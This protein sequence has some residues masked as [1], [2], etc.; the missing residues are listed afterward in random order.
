MHCC[1]IRNGLGKGIFVLF[2]NA[3]IFMTATRYAS[4]GIFKSKLL[5]IKNFF[6]GR[7]FKGRMES[8]RTEEWGSVRVGGAEVEW[9][10]N[11]CQ[12]DCNGEGEGLESSNFLRKLFHSVTKR[13][14]SQNFQY[15]NGI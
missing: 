9:C 14:T 2:T 5:R 10:Q 12:K 4:Q 3:Q 13:L 8:G 15:P 11:V 7:S 6:F 1:S